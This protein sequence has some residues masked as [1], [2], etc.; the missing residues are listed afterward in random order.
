MSASKPNSRSSNSSPSS[1]SSLISVTSPDF[2]EFLPTEIIQQVFSYIGPETLEACLFVSK[3]WNVHT[4]RARL[5]RGK[6]HVKIRF[7]IT[8]SSIQDIQIGKAHVYWL[9]KND[10]YPVVRDILQGLCRRH[11][12]SEIS[13]FEWSFDNSFE[14]DI[15]K[16]LS[17]AS[18]SILEMQFRISGYLDRVRHHD[19]QL[20]VL[21]TQTLAAEEPL[22]CGIIVRHKTTIL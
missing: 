17:A 5:A 15:F 20:K 13:S 2:T 12:L 18:P 16:L 8:N 14:A 4:L 21:V 10:E 7:N 9:W 3:R 22:L 19:N 1:K 6:R 11:R